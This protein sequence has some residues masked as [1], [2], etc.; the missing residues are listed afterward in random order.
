M[1]GGP[2]DEPE[3][4]CFAPDGVSLRE[5]DITQGFIGVMALWT[6]RGHMF[7]PNAPISSIW[8]ALGGILTTAGGLPL[9]SGTEATSSRPWLG[10]LAKL[11]VGVA[12]LGYAALLRRRERR[13]IAR[14]L[15]PPGDELR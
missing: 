15:M 10:S 5:L 11:V 3:P 9:L 2:G 7:K 1:R 12:V 4:F 6:C 8:F 13:L 14:G